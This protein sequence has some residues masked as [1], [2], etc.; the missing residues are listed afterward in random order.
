MHHRGEYFS[1][2]QPPADAD[3]PRRLADREVTAGEIV[4]PK[5]RHER[6]CRTGPG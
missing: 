2:R 6:E 4:E 1:C 5:P 3:G